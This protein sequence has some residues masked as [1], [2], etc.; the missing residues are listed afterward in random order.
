MTEFD[1]VLRGGE[2]FDGTGGEPYIADVAVRDGRI[3]SVGE[4]SGTGKEEID[5][6][7][8]IVTPGFVDIHTH[9]DGQITW[10]NRLAPSSGHGVTTVVMGNCG[11]GFAPVRPTDHELVVKLMEGVED[12]PDVVMTAGVPW[13]WE[14]FPDY[15]DA[16]EQRESDIDFAAQLPHSPLRV[17]VMGE[18]GA[19]LEPPTDADL[20]EM[21]RLT[22]EAVRAGALGVST[23]RNYAHRFKDGRLAPSVPTEDEEIL[24][25]A[26]GLRDAGAGVFQLLPNHDVPVKKRFALIEELARTSGRPVSFTF[27]QSPDEGDAWRETLKGLDRANAEGLEIRG[28]VIGRPTASMLGLELSFHPFAL[29]PSF[30]PLANLPLAEKVAAM[31]DPELRR[32]LLAEEPADPN[33]FFLFLISETEMLFRLGDPPNYHPDPETSM[34]AIARASGRGVME[35]IYDVLLEREGREILYRPLGNTAGYRFQS[36]GRN[37]VP[38]DHTVVALGDGG[39][40]YSSI[41]DAAYTTYFLTYWS[42]D[43]EADR[44]VDLPV[45]IRKL[46]LDPAKAVGLCDRG[47]IKE[48]YKADL[49]VID[50]DRLHL[51]APVPIYDL[52]AGGRRL[53]QRADGYVATIVSGKV[54]YKGGEPTGALPG[55]LVRGAKA[56]PA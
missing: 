27:M 14:T 35:V 21:R 5:A 18:R 43:A 29:H 1:V 52:P 26:A 7:G 32:K 13:N 50:L 11:V 49:N 3:V 41:C 34:G 30:R 31:R 25:L 39:A 54:T 12:I 47:L 20:A 16:L 17:Y 53:S 51:H 6:R 23:S 22:A 9:Y 45:A 24:A 44:K 8:C 33:P 15:L 46:A 48:G 38:N 37:L 42:R 55:R 19:N 28:Q 56:A 36:S 10:E 2:I 4:V 40:H